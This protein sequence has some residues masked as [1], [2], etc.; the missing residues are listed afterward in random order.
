MWCWIR[1][2]LN[3][4]KDRDNDKRQDSELAIAICGLACAVRE[5]LEWF[6][7]HLQSATLHD[8]QQMERRLLMT[9]QELEQLLNN[10]TTQIIKI[11]AEQAGRFDTLT[12]KIAE[13]QALIEAGGAGGQI[14]PA[15]VAAA[16]AVGVAL[17]NLDAAIPDAVPTPP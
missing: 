13:L 6:K 3:V 15:L 4:P 14:T 10:R 16:E 12:A 8:L 7:S 1:K 9:S 17:D 5:S 11:S 2:L